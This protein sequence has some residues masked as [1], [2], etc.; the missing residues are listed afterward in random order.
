M[1]LHPGVQLILMLSP[2][3]SILKLAIQYTSFESVNE[4]RK[5]KKHICAPVCGFFFQCAFLS[6]LLPHTLFLSLCWWMFVFFAGFAWASWW[7]GREWRRRRDGE[8]SLLPRFLL[9]SSDSHC[10]HVRLSEVGNCVDCSEDWAGDLS[11]E[12]PPASWN[13]W[14]VRRCFKK[15]I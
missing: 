9:S 15:K 11:L 13:K 2:L 6:Q 10:F 4:L 1:C 14:K 3:R 7:E 12:T 8:F 5:K